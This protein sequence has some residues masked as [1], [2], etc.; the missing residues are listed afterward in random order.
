MA[1]GDGA[2]YN[3][4]KK[5]VLSGNHNHANGGNTFKLM[6]LTAHSPNIDTHANYDDISGDEITGTGYTQYGE[7]LTGQVVTKDNTN[8][9]GKWDASAVTWTGLDAGTPSHAVLYDDTHASDSL[10]C[11][12][13]VATASNGGDYTI[14]WHAT[15]GILLLT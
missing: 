14:D 4:W 12:F 6:L 3:E 5:E 15:S 7:T 9:L 10:V 2:L 11:Y 8:D 1:E 13:E